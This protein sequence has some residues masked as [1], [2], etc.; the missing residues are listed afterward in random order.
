LQDSFQSHFCDFAEEADY[1]SHFINSLPFSEQ[2]IMKMP[3]N[4]QMELIDLKA[5]SILKPNF[6]E[7]F[8]LLRASEISVSC[9]P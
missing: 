5:N 2:T 8:S 6:D 1:I 9:D 7:L 3:N 4:I